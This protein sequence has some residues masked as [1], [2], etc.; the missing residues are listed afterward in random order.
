[1]IDHFVFMQGSKFSRQCIKSEVQERE[2]QFGERGKWGQC[3]IRGNVTKN[4]GKCP[5]T[6]LA[7]SPNVLENVAK[8]SGECLQTFQ[9][10]LLNIPRNFAEHSRKH[11]QTFWGMSSGNVAKFLM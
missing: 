5:Q 1:M 11:H 7:M 9:E 4:F 8:H 10:M 3:Y 6:F 2:T